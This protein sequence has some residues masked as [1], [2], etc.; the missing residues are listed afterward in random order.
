MTPDKVIVTIQTAAGQCWGD[1]ELPASIPVERFQERL[2]E[3]L[4]QHAPQQFGSWAGL[5]LSVGGRRI[6][7]GDTLAAHGVWD[8]SYVVVSPGK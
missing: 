7:E 6:P 5:A 3:A 2:L 4:R 8:G 1:Y